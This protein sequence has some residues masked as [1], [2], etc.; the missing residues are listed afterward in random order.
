MEKLSAFNPNPHFIT[1]GFPITKRHRQF[2]LCRHATLAASRPYP[3]TIA[4]RAPYAPP[5][6]PPSVAPSSSVST[7]ITTYP[8][9]WH[10]HSHSARLSPLTVRRL[11][12]SLT[13]VLSN[14]KRHLNT[15]TITLSSHRNHPHAGALWPATQLDCNPW[16]TQ[17]ISLHTSHDILGL[18]LFVLYH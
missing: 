5:A 2:G 10:Y 9:C 8:T 17:T 16:H 3:H 12:L 18:V 13:P 6:P 4:P 15:H 11:S 7:G 1:Q 14:L